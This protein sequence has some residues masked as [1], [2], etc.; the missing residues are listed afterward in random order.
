MRSGDVPGWGTAST[1]PRL[2]IKDKLDSARM[3]KEI[4]EKKS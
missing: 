1:I 2:E 3:A 4:L